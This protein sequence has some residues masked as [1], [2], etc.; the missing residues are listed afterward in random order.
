MLAEHMELQ[1]DPMDSPLYSPT[2]PADS[3]IQDDVFRIPYDPDTGEKVPADAQGDP[4]LLMTWNLRVGSQLEIKYGPAAGHRGEVVGRTA[5][6]HYLVRFPR[7]VGHNDEWLLRRDK[8]KYPDE[9]PRAP[10]VYT[11]G[12]WWVEAAA[13]GECD[14]LPFVSFAPAAPAAAAAVVTTIDQPHATAT[15]CKLNR[16]RK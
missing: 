10:R 3:I 1:V 14:R 13:K 11:M 12:C 4:S 16:K 15:G 9:D 6:G 2:L 8:K 5:H 7:I